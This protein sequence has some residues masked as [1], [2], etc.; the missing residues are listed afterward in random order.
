[1][2]IDQTEKRRALARQAIQLAPALMDVLYSL[3]ALR[4]KRDSG[5]AAGTALVFTD[6]DF[7]GQTGLTH[8]DAATLNAC[9][10]AIPTILA[11]FIAQNF[12]DVFEAVRP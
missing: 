2:A 1:M 3:D 11:A 10:A 8:L 9:M 12:D 5:G 6:A 4:R 7:T